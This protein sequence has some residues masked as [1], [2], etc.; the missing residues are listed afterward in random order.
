MTRKLFF[1]IIF[2]IILTALVVIVYFG[3]QSLIKATSETA[4]L[5]DQ[6]PTTAAVTT[7]LITLT[8]TE[9]DYKKFLKNPAVSPDGKQLAFFEKQADGNHLKIT[10]V[11]ANKINFNELI[12]FEDV[13]VGWYKNDEIFLIE[14]P[15]AE[16]LSS[17]WLFDLKNK[18]IQPLARNEA[19][20]IMSWSN[21]ADWA[22]KL[23]VVNQTPTL[24][25]INNQKGLSFKMPFI[26]LPNKCAFDGNFI[27]CAV[28][29]EIPANTVLPDD[30]LK[31][32][33]ISR[34]NILTIN[35][36]TFKTELLISRESQV[37]DAVDLLIKDGFLY[38]TNR[39]DGK[40]YRF[41]LSE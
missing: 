40:V 11:K 12:N 10:G 15:S 26:T 24:T 2:I 33:F 31:G 29:S 9:E 20:L 27:Y 4:P 23:N 25:L 32:K 34:D 1:I 19:G 39:H 41:N 18:T 37:I 6:L 17:I 14:K 30:Y 28:P 38:F 36:Q 16:I 21:N 22:L 8:E 13:E 5:A 35:A 7:E 3:W